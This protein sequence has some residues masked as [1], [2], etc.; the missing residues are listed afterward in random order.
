M[1]SGLLV[2][3]VAL[4][5][6][7]GRAR[8][9]LLTSVGGLLAV[10]MVLETTSAA[11]FK[12]NGP[13]T[14]DQVVPFEAF[15]YLN[16][17]PGLLRVPSAAERGAM[18]ARLEAQEYR[19][20]LLQDPKQFVA[21]VEPHLAQFWGLRLVEGY[22]AGLPRRLS[23]LPF[24]EGMLSPHDLDIG[25]SGEIPWRLL[26]A[27]NVK[28]VVSVDRSLWFNPSPGLADPPVD[29]QRLRVLESPYP[30]T[31]RAFFAARVAAG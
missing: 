17:P 22:G 28:Y 7:L 23:M 4:G 8:P 21:H 24:T 9:S 10:W 15:D 2:L 25:R 6:L 1:V 5:L 19:V 30:V 11:D 26:A 3:L 14:R 16:A 18:Q 31:P 29:P 27:L 20:A 12:L 13:Q